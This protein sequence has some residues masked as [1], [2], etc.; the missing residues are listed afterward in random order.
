MLIH[1]KNYE[2]NRLKPVSPEKH[3]KNMIV[4]EFEESIKSGK[5]KVSAIIPSRDNSG[6]IDECISSLIKNKGES[7]DLEIIVV[8]NGSSDEERNRK[9]SFY[10]SCFFVGAKFWVLNTWVVYCTKF[11]Y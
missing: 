4:P 5:V 7:T 8:D 1:V 2:A 9:D 6:L 11:I 10:L 3:V